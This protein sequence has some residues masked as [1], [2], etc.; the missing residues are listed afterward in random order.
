MDA[1][2]KPEGKA[3]HELYPRMRDA[4]NK[5]GKPV[6]FYA[7]VWGSDHVY[8]WGAET[9]NLWRTTGDICSPGHASFNRMLKN[10]FGN[11]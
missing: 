10:F 6:V 3:Y 8:E 11:T 9:A 5:T 2:H 7:C 1:C 4:L